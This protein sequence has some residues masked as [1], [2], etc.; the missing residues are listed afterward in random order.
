MMP[1]K[2]LMVRVTKVQKLKKNILKNRKKQI[3]FP[4]FEKTSAQYHILHA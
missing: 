4:F 1:Q 2:W 3:F